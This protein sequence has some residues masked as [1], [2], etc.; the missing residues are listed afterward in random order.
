MRMK[1]AIGAAE[2]LV[3]HLLEVHDSSYG[4]VSPEGFSLGCSGVQNSFYGSSTTDHR[5][6]L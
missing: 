5:R 2:R 1:E 6:R 4:C 3:R